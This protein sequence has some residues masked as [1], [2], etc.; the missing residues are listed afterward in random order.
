MVTVLIRADRI[1]EEMQSKFG[2]NSV[3]VY[4]VLRCVFLLE[5]PQILIDD[6]ISF[7]E[8]LIEMKVSQIML[9]MSI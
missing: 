1:L 5:I 4:E 6:L 3:W 9:K 8:V 2:E 7:S